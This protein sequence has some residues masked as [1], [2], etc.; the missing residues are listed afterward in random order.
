M[1]TPIII[2]NLKKSFKEQDVLK[3]TDLCIEKGTV[4]GMLGRNG[5]G[6][7]TLIKCLLGLLRADDGSATLL[8]DDAMSLSPETKEKLGY[9]PQEAVLYP[10]MRIK[11]LISYQGSFYTRW[12]D[13]LVNQMLEKFDLD[14][15]KRV[16]T[17]SVGQLQKLAITLALSHEPEVLILDEPVASLDPAGRR[18]FLK[19][20]LDMVA[21]REVTVLI[22]SHIT[23][24]I[25]RVCSHVGM[26]KDG[27]LI[28]QGELD[29]LK[30]SEQTGLEDIF[31]EM[32]SKETGHE[33]V[34]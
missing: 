4:F 24:D 5:A 30:D 21:D 14:P 2:E 19:M 3:G 6:K 10:W 28:W 17:L 15:K 9:V 11:Q 16:A 22:S 26:L 7:S 33:K 8:G 25:E 27:K 31:L 12:N 20:M 18:D 13:D 32:T 23:S 1:K 29:E 34:S